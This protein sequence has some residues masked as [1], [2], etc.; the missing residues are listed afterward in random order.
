MNARIDFDTPNY[1][2]IVVDIPLL[3][4][5]RFT[6][7][8]P[9][10]IT[11]PYGAKVKV[12]FG[13]KRQR[14]GYVVGPSSV[15]KADFEIKQV[16]GVYD[17]R[18]LP[19]KHLLRFGEILKDYYLA[20]TASFWKLMWPPAVTSTRLEPGKSY[21]A[22][23]GRGVPDNDK[24][25]ADGLAFA[26]V[27]F[28]QG[29]FSARWDSYCAKIKQTLDLGKGVLVLVPEIRRINLVMGVLRPVHDGPISLIHSGLS[30][31]LRREQWLNL[32]VGRSRLALGTRIAVF[33]P[34]QNLGLIIVDEEESDSYK[35]QEFP[36]FNARTVARARGALEQIDVVLGSFVPSVKTRY[37]IDQGQ[38]QLERPYV[39]VSS[40]ETSLDTVSMLGRKKRLVISEEVHL[41]LKDVFDRGGRALLF[42]NRRGTAA[43]LMCTDCGNTVMCPRCSVPL[44]YH[45]RG[46]EMVCHTCGF[47]QIPPL[48]C[49]V[50]QG[51]TWKPLGYG[52]GRVV[53]EFEKRF[54][55]VPVLPFDQDSKSPDAVIEQFQVLQPS[56]LLCTQKV[57]GFSVPPIECLGVLSCDNVLSFP[58]YSAPE[59]VFRLLMN[60]LHLLKNSGGH[61]RKKFIVQ[62]LNPNHHA[63]LAV[64]DAE[65]FYAQELKNRADLN[66]P[67]FGALFKVVFSGKNPCKVEEIAYAFARE[68]EG[69]SGNIR[70]LGPGPAPKLKVRGRFRWMLMLKSQ[71]RQELSDVVNHVGTKVSH[72][73]VRITVDTEEPFGMG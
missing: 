35:A 70:I 7:R 46:S 24:V 59:Q 18:F 31:K 56:C 27:S 60:L 21:Y 48:K 38:V 32:L 50:C 29:P 71:S 33:S 6:Y 45:G 23:S 43:S 65:S 12:P 25:V 57:L 58:D 1:V 63:I 20:P 5:R 11:L 49:P 14:D 10:G 4:D 67:P 53:S 62:T 52:I 30:E 3:G 44:A 39:P 19:P 41:A 40:T 54:P 28:I 61:E 55:R 2:D 72:N 22:S 16:T 26:G 64:R 51:Y 36:G 37:E 13:G 9:G 15:E 66:Y 34:V 68:A 17:P 47:R 73:Q 69:P 42:L 8:I